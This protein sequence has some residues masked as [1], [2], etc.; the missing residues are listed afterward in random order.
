MIWW[1]EQVPANV[2]D[3]L[4]SRVTIYD[5]DDVIRVK[6]KGHRKGAGS[7]VILGYDMMSCLDT[8]INPYKLATMSDGTIKL[9]IDKVEGRWVTL[10]FKPVLNWPEGTIMI[11]SSEDWAKGPYAGMDWQEVWQEEEHTGGP[12]ETWTMYG[13]FSMRCK[14]VYRQILLKNCNSNPNSYPGRRTFGGVGL[15]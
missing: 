5:L 15:S 8:V 4:G 1:A 6:Q 2:L 14:D 9:K 11:S 10:T 13:D 7:T 3:K 12:I